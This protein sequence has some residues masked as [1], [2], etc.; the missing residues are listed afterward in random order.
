MLNVPENPQVVQQVELTKSAKV[1][2]EA[3]AAFDQGDMEQGQKLLKAQA[4]QMLQMSVTMSSPVMAEE[5]A[6]LYS[7]LENFE[8]SSK[9]RN[10][11]HQEKYRRMKRK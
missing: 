10:E 7:Q 8:Y 6:K 5:S 3:M 1:I 9:K 2:E 4:D 11:L